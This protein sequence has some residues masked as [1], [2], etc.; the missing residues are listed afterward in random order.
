MVTFSDS[1]A[2]SYHLLKEFLCSFTAIIKKISNLKELLIF[3]LPVLEPRSG[4]GGISRRDAGR[5]RCD[6]RS[7]RPKRSAGSIPLT[8]VYQRL[9]VKKTK[10]PRGS[11]KKA[12][13]FASAFV[14]P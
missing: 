12:E 9:G 6:R 3:L 8:G 11:T 14:L 7:H 2:Y 1:G 4:E 10:S 13:A 5:E